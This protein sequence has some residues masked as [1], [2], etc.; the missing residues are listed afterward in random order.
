MSEKQK[1]YQVPAIE[2]PNL[3]SINEIT[4]KRMISSAPSQA[5]L[6]NYDVIFGNKDKTHYPY[7]ALQGW[8]YDFGGNRGQIL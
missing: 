7:N 8:L 5:Y 2:Y 3:S 1:P 6:D 4:G